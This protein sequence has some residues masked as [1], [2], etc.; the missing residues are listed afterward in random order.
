M[1]LF[2]KMMLMIF[3]MFFS[4]IIM[5]LENKKLKNLLFMNFMLVLL[6]LLVSF[7]NSMNWQMLYGFLGIDYLSFLMIFLTIWIMSLMFLVIF[8]NMSKLI[9][10]N[11]M[12]LMFSLM[13]CFMSMNYFIFYLMFEISL[14]PTFYLILG[15]GYQPERMNAGMYM[16][17]YTLFASLP[18]MILIFYL[19]KKMNTLNYLYLLNSIQSYDFMNEFFYIVMI[20]AFVIKLPVFLFHYW[21]PKAHVEAP[22]VGSMILA[23]VMLKLGGYGI[24]RSL[25]MMINLSIKYNFLLFSMSLVGLL[26][27]SILCL[28]QNDMKLMVAYSSVV[29][30]GLMLMGLLTFSMIGYMGGLIMMLGHGLCSSAMF[31]IVNLMYERSKSRNMY[32]S[33][34]FLMIYPILSM[35]WFMMCVNN[36]SS[37]PSLN[38]LSELLLI[39]SSLNWSYNIIFILMIGMYLSASYSLYLYTF[40]NHGKL[41]SYIIKNKILTINEFMGILF[42]WIPLNLLFLKM[43]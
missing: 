27:L 10:M 26:N 31:F 43:M 18:L 6:I 30:M 8:K 32:L 41:S 13:L 7:N 12:F 21:L 34:G 3:I 17:L 24:M 15:F 1:W 11:L 19:F 35:W 29:H 28:R 4:V 14:I 40:S 2:N 37:P 25:L 20:F 38:L 42:H 5:M 23:G 39:C 36:M 16:L 22:L 9:V 33:K